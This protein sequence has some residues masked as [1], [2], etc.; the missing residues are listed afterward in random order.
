MKKI[1][2]VGVSGAGKSTLARQ[3]HRELGLQVHHL[4]SLF[5]KPGWEMPDA[6]EWEQKLKALARQDSW[7]IDGNFASSYSILMPTADV[8]LVLEVQTLVAI[9]RVLKR[10]I[11]TRLRLRH[12][13]DAPKGCIEK[14]DSDFIAYIWNFSRDRKPLLQSALMEYGVDKKIIHIHN[15]GNIESLKD[16]LG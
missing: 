4:D 12:K 15:Q 1:L 8:I 16:L 2:I 6:Q 13:E 10:M 7:I 3:L 14:F 9:Y 11:M 5:W